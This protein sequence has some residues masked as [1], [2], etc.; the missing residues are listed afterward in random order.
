MRPDSDKWLVPLKKAVGDSAVTLICFP[1]AG[2][3]PDLF[4]TW[5][6]GMSDNI[7]L[8]AV[9]LPGRGSRISETPYRDWEM[10]LADTYTALSSRL[11]EPH[12]FYGHSF[13]G[14][15]AYE[16]AHHAAVKYSGHTRHLFV[17]GCRSPNHPQA[18]PY[19]HQLPEPEFRAALRDMGG[20]PA[21]LL[22]DERLMKLLIPTVRSDIR[23][24]ELWDDRHGTPLD[25][26]LTVLY[27]RDDRVDGRDNM[28][29]WPAFSRRQCE[30]IEMP[31]GHFFP[32]TYRRQLLDVINDRLRE[33]SV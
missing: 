15:L 19:L 6:A 8:I 21:E 20:T 24:A 2:S 16:V 10:L 17:S 13:G 3:G 23:L 4:R 31:G 28:C 7:G 30:L 33:S 26:L 1:Y 9:R 22:N 11:R 29:G 27:G 12:A 14:R 18:R 32:N 25:V 5:S